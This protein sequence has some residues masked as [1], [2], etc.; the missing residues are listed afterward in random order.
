MG[1]TAEFK[2]T[3]GYRLFTAAAVKIWNGLIDY[4]RKE[5]DFDKFKRLIKTTR[6]R[7]RLRRFSFQPTRSIISR[8][9]RST[10]AIKIVTRTWKPRSVKCSL[11]GCWRKATK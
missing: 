2:C 4:I 9:C 10:R 8:R 6:S 5:N 1:V 3:L 11:A 7:A